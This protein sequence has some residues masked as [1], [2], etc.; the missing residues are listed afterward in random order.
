MFSLVSSNEEKT[1]LHSWDVLQHAE[2]TKRKKGKKSIIYRICKY[3]REQQEEKKKVKRINP[4]AQMI[5]LYFCCCCFL[6]SFVHSFIYLFSLLLLYKLGGRI[7]FV[8][9]RKTKKRKTK[10]KRKRKSLSLPS[11]LTL[12]MFSFFVWNS[13]WHL[14][15]F[16]FA[17]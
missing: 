17:F 5:M 1:K 16:G 14:S 10:M 11:F 15:F 7:H 13:K 4:V 8:K 12:K 3:I 6:R 9:K 2:S